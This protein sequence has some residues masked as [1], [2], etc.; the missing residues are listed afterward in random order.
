MFILWLERLKS[1]FGIIGVTI[2]DAEL[3]V[4]VTNS[5]TIDRISDLAMESCKYVRLLVLKA[6]RVNA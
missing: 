5:E 3:F 4:E 6:S 1:G 2:D